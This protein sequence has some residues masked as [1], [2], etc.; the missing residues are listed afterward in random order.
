[1]AMRLSALRVCRSLLLLIVKFILKSLKN[2]QIY[3]KFW[4]N[5]IKKKVKHYIYF[6]IHNNLTNSIWGKENCLEHGRSLLL[7]KFTRRAIKLTK[8]IIETYHY[9]KLTK[10]TSIFLSRISQYVD[11]ITVGHQ[12]RFRCKRSA[13]DQICIRQILGKIGSIMR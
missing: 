11:D 2:C 9:Y 12:H 1:M 13:T 5:W 4:Q 7:Y 10:F 3:I 8:V 6:D